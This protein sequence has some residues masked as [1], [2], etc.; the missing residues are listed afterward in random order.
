MVP[1]IILWPSHICTHACTHTSYTCAPT[2]TH[3]HTQKN[4]AY[5]PLISDLTKSLRQLQRALRTDEQEALHYSHRTSREHH[6]IQSWAVTAKKLC[7]VLRI[8]LKH[9]L[10]CQC[11]PVWPSEKQP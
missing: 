2:A 8:S 9:S 11:F 4:L 1:R 5:R 6:L 10:D 7:G 3:I